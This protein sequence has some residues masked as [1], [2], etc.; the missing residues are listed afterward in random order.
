MLQ[1]HSRRVKKL[2]ETV[3]YDF[4]LK[5]PLKYID[6]FINQTGHL[7][8]VNWQYGSQHDGGN[9]WTKSWWI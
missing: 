3:E 2:N 6:L 9:D 7:D 8:F 4:K 5:L 1:Y